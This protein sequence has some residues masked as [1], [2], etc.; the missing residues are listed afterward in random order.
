MFKTDDL[1]DRQKEAMEWTTGPELILAGAGSGK[2]RVLTR[3]IAYLIAEKK[4]DPWNIMAIT[5]TNKAAEEM[6]TRVNGLSGEDA[7]AV[8]IATFHASCVRILRRFIDRIGYDNHFTIYDADDSKTLMK[9]IFKD[10][11]VD[12]RVFR[13]RNVLTAISHAKEEMIGPEDFLKSAEGFAEQKTGE[14]YRAYQN[15]LRKNNALDFDDLLKMTVMLFQQCPDV[16]KHY[17][18]RFRY[19]MVDEYQDTNAVQFT[20]VKLLA[21]KYKNICVVGDDD[22]SIYKFR[23]ADIRNILNFEEAFPGAKVIKLEQNYRSTGNI[24]NAANDVIRNNRGRKEK[25][26]WTSNGEGERVRII[27]YEKASDEAKEVIDDIAKKAEGHDFGRFAVLYRTNAQSR[28]LEE[29]C[30][31]L[32]IPYQLIGGVNFYQRKEIKDILAYLK[33]IAN[34]KDDLAAMRIINVPKRGIGG[35][36]IDKISVFSNARGMN[37]YQACLQIPGT[38]ILPAAEE[39]IKKFTGMIEDFREK[40]RTMTIAGLI[41][42]VCTESGY[43]D[44]LKEEG[45]IEAQTRLENIE[46]LISKA[47]SFEKGQEDS[48]VDADNGQPGNAGLLSL[49]DRFLEEVALVAD[50][51]RME[52]GSS[53]K[54]TLMTLHA[55]KGLEFPDVYMV[56]MEEGLFPG[57]M[58]IASNDE[59]ELEEERR[60]CYVGITR[61]R[62]HLTMTSARSR[63]IN[64]EQRFSAVSRFIKEIPAEYTEAHEDQNSYENSRWRKYAGKEDFPR[65]VPASPPNR[66]K[67]SAPAKPAMFGKEFVVKKADSLDYAVGD[68]VSHMK[69]GTGKVLEIKDG[70]RDYEI[71][72]DFAEFGVKKMF[73]GFARLQKI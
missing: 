53:G 57:N 14:C 45:E 9:K 6:R 3:R 22:Q 1:N 66:K 37:F 5:F 2:T 38:G 59:S 67:V 17:Q 65:E 44:E 56:G 62:E 35:T 18:E 34:G 41:D 54:I 55:A 16:L 51:D 73:A 48:P 42:L 20:F 4:I 26:L 71:T 15:G 61:A 31:S 43:T 60:L 11:N 28:L 10:L 50:V 70:G 68:T 29:K 32:G 30:V 58:A 64:G 7:G 72:V 39:K 27:R 49:L 23:G 46:E 12:T 36:T 69:F 13:E 33:T 40:S 25:R 47:A 63:M 19:L 8:W 24:L 21:G 52:D